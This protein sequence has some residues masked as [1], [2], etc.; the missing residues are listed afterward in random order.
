[1]PGEWLPPEEA[2]HRCDLPDLDHFV[3]AG[4]RRPGERWKC[5]CGAVYVVEQMSQHGESWKQFRK[6]TAG[7]ERN[8]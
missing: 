7:F 2:P 4:H 8:L 3:D 6:L 5:D 1:M